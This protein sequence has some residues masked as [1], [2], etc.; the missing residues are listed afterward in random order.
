MDRK[1]KINQAIFLVFLGMIFMLILGCNFLTP[2]VMDDFAYEFSFATKER[3]SNIWE[4]FPSLRQHAELLNGRLVAHF[5]VQIF[6][7]LPKPIFNFVNTAMF[8]SEIMLIYGLTKGKTAWNFPLL[9]GIFCSVW[10]FQ[11]TFGQVN[12]WLDGACNYLWGSV[13]ALLYLLPYVFLFIY[14]KKI[15]GKILR[16]LYVIAGVFVGWYMENITP[17]LLIII[18]MILLKSGKK[19]IRLYYILPIITLVIGYAALLCAPAEISRKVGESSLRV[20]FSNFMSCIHSYSELW[21]LFAVY[22]V[23]IL[24]YIKK[25]LYGEKEFFLSLV[26]A[27]AALVSGFMLIFASYF[28]ERC[29]FFS[30]VLLICAVFLLVA[31]LYDCNGRIFIECAVA[32]LAFFTLFQIYSGV[33]D[34][35]NTYSKIQKNEEYIIE[36]KENGELNIVIPDVH[37]STKYSAIYDAVYIKVGDAK[38]W[39]NNSMALHYEVNSIIGE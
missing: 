15:N 1:T 23:L 18:C 34:I 19:N 20:M 35:Y 5:F 4:I 16:I 6:E 31:K 11:P 28:V 9:V 25:K 37:S 29:L 17:A 8:L 27:F 38:G 14:D 2:K 36:C 21:I 12:F 30:A 22:A 7:M 24:V 10:C 39:P 33:N 26:L 13:F 32:V 3:I